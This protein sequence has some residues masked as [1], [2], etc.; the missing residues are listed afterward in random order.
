MMETYLL[1]CLYAFVACVAFAVLF[2]I[3]GTGLLICGLGGALGWLAYLLIHPVTGEPVASSFFAALV[4]S[5]YSEGMSRLRK[6]PV[7]GY[8][9]VAFFPLVPGGGIFHTMKYCL[10][11]DTH[12]FLEKG[13]ETLGIAGALAAGVI[14]VSSA[15]RLYTGIR[16]GKGERR[17]TL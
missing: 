7:T 10:D 13:L 11:G 3:H 5:A 17:E 6:C 1:P 14:L 9:L 15:V 8:L 4:I 12:R 2:N 16:R